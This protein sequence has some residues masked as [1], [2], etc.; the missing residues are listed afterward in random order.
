MRI[1]HVVDMISQT[2]GGGSA[3]VPYELAK[4]QAKLGHDVTIFSSD[5]RADGLKPPDGVKLVMSKCVGNFKGGLRITPGIV[6]YE[7]SNYDI[8]HLH[9]YVTLQNLWASLKEPPFVLQA[10][11]SAPVIYSGKWRYI[12]NAV[13]GNMV[14]KRAAAC[15]A[16]SKTELQQYRVQG[17]KRTAL[18]DIG[19]DTAPY[20]DL[21]ARQHYGG[22]EI[23]YLGKLHEIKGVDI[24]LDAFALLRNRRDDIRLLLAYW[25]DGYAQQLWDKASKLNIDFDIV[26]MGY[27]T[28]KDK[29]QAFVDADVWVSPSRYETFGLGVVESLMCGTPAV[30]TDQFQAFSKILPEYCGYVKEANA[31]DIASGINLALD[32]NLKDKY[33]AERIAWASKYSWDNLAPQYIKLY[34]NILLKRL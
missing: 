16:D 22:K 34:K 33:Q 32:T 7:F 27:L 30:I 5:D 28:G 14:M 6:M 8:I 25:D 2:R 24:L 3:I 1:L 21:P 17:A 15:I 4:A 18:M 31:A 11:G 19:I 23:L 26:D 12:R 13:W 20:Q 10:H 29:I 9:N